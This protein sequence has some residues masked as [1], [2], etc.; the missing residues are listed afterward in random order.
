MNKQN[1]TEKHTE[2]N[3]KPTNPY[4]TPAS[5]TNNQPKYVYLPRTRL[6][7]F[8]PLSVSLSAILLFV[9]A[10]ALA[11]WGDDLL[12]GQFLIGVPFFVGSWIAYFSNY[13]Q[14]VAITTIVK[15]IAI[16]LLVITIICAPLL[17]EGVICIVMASPILFIMMWLGGVLTHWFCH[18]IWQSKVMHSIALLPLLVLFVPLPETNH[19]YQSNHSIIINATP[20]KIW[21]AINNIDNIQTEEFYQNSQLLPFMQVPTPKSATTVLENGRWVRKCQWHKGIYFDEP[22]VSQIPN[23]QLRWQFVF[24]PDSVPPKTLDDHVTING[25]HFKLLWGQYDIT[26]INPQQSKLSFKVSY[27]VTTNINFYAGWW[28]NLVMDEFNQDVLT[29]YKNRIE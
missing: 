9:L 24:Y 18:Y 8:L 1:H 29:L 11:G 2:Q 3:Q 16:T 14:K 19:T 4:Q 6:Q 21:Q 17:K 7:K 25:E 26:A 22:I 15:R 13:Q 10:H 12:S 28:A 5:Q 23:Q 20:D 27:R